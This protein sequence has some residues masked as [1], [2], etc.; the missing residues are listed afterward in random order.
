MPKDAVAQG[1]F[2]H[3]N[4]NHKSVLMTLRKYDTTLPQRIEFEHEGV[5]KLVNVPVGAEPKVQVSLPPKTDVRVKW[6]GLNFVFNTE[7][8]F[9]HDNISLA[10]VK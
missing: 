3:D 1:G 7:I 4:P 6:G 5:T 8:G 9:A 2:G 10:W